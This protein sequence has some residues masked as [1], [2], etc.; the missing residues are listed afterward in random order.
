MP[1]VAAHEPAATSR[2]RIDDRGAGILRPCRRADVIGVIEQAAQ[3]GTRVHEDGAHP[4]AAHPQQ[5][6]DLPI[7]VAVS[8]EADGTALEI[9]QRRERRRKRK[10]FANSLG[11]VAATQRRLVGGGTAGAAVGL[12]DAD[13]DRQLLVAATGAAPGPQRVERAT[14][15]G[16]LEIGQPPLGHKRPPIPL[17]PHPQQ[18]L[19]NDGFSIDGW[20]APQHAGDV[21]LAQGLMSSDEG[22]EGLPQIWLWGRSV[23]GARPPGNDASTAR[24]PGGH[25]AGLFTGDGLLIEIESELARVV[26]QDAHAA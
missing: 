26:L 13:V 9:R 8:L 10:A 1:K 21:G 2:G 17:T 14:P 4:L 6:G 20:L 3:Q 24:E 7:A 5:G 18:R 11:G 16:A 22:G 12:E 15:Q 23:A 25:C 19:L